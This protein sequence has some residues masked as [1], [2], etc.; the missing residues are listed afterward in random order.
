MSIGQ[1]N[2]SIGMQTQNSIRDGRDEMKSRHSQQYPEYPIYTE[3]LPGNNTAIQ[4]T[5]QKERPSLEDVKAS[6]DGE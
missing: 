3:K 5:I 1:T 2:S 4:S 6:F